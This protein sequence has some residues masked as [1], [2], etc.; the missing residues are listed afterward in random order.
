MDHHL[1]EQDNPYAIIINNQIQEYPNKELSGAGVTWQFCRYID[2]ILNVNYADKYLDLV[3]LG[4][5]ADMMSM[6]SIETKH[7]VNKGFKN[8]TNPFFA[9]LAQKNEFSMKGKINHTSVA[10]YIAPYINAIC[11]SGTIEEKTLVFESMLYHKAF[12][13]LLSTK[14]GHYLGETERLVDQA[15]R[16]AINVKSRQTKAQDIGM[17]RLE[18]KIENE[19]LLDHKVIFFKLEPGEIDRNIAGLCAN[20]IMAK[21]Q[22]PVM[23]LTRC[24]NE[25]ISIKNG[26]T[27]EA[28]T[29]VTYEGSARGCDKIDIDDFKAICAET[30]LTNYLIGHQNAFGASINVG[31][32]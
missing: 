2:S 13:E 23:V 16:A 27:I 31:K 25:I 19:H 3:A 15:I 12:K 17:Q 20:K 11:R 28:K 14:R 5:C 32:I 10:F 29:Q 4:L 21:Y 30:G 22:R 26:F 18:E 8:V 24:E 1:K 7:L 6:T 9:L